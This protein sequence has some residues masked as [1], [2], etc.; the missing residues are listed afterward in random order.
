VNTVKDS[1]HGVQGAGFINVAVND[2]EGGQGAG[3]ANVSRGSMDEIQGAGFLNVTLK[4]AHGVQGAGFLNLTGGNM[5]GGQGSGLL[6]VTKG[7]FNGGQIAGFLNTTGGTHS[8]FQAAGFLNVAKTLKG[9]QIGIINV[10]D[11]IEDGAQ[12][13]LLSFSRNDYKRL[14]LIGSETFY[15]QMNIKLG[16]K[17]FY[18]IFSAGTRLE[19]S[20]FIWAL[21]YGLGTSFDLSEKVDLSLEGITY[22]VNEGAFWTS[23]WNNLNKINAGLSYKLNKNLAVYG[24][25]SLNIHLS[26]MYDSD[27]QTF[28][29][30]AAPY[31]KYTEVVGNTQV[32]I[33]PGFNF[34]ISII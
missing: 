16:M 23:Q 6:N 15:G 28:T 4:D 8:G 22:H 31:S 9:V 5:E 26:K 19:N 3:F 21:G 27:S 24:G 7:D 30:T 32:Q 17:H 11:S 14:D 20:D 1:M 25:G 12:F 13:G 34:G 33:Y 10:A 18:N 2:V 29:S